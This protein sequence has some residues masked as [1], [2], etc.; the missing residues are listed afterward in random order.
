MDVAEELRLLTHL[1]QNNASV[2]YPLTDKRNELIQDINAPE[3]K[4]YGVLFSFAIHSV[5]YNAA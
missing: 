4:R 5:S 2:S 1:K 3:G